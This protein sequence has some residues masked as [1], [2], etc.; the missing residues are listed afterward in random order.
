MRHLKYSS[1]G[2]LILFTLTLFV[3]YPSELKGQGEDFFP[4]GAY[5]SMSSTDSMNQVLDAGFNVLRAG[6][7]N[8]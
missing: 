7:G 8:F 5:S 6:D 1:A 3:F 4:R 2:L